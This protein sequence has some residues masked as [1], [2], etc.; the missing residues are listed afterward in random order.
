MRY[1]REQQALEFRTWGGRR[2][3]AGRKPIGSK[4]GVPH[5][6]RPIHCSRH[7]VHVTLR[8]APGLPSMRNQ[9]LFTVLR[10]GL[11]CASRSWFR[12][13]HFSVQTNHVHLLV[14]ADEGTRPLGREA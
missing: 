2:L 9:V 5:R 4:P 7:P 14:E 11:A 6:P 3:G 13:I 10:R 12:L 8:V 1:R